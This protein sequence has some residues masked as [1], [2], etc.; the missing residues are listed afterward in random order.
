MFIRTNDAAIDATMDSAPSARTRV[1]HAYSSMK[2]SF[3]SPRE[4]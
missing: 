4:N 3:F 1:A 2:N